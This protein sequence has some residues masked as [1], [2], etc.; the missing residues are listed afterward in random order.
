MLK[1]FRPRTEKEKTLLSNVKGIIGKKTSNLALYQLAVRHS[2]VSKESNERL[3]FLGDAILGSVVAEYLFKKYPYKDEGFLTE[4]R[5][6]IVKRDSLNTIAQ[7]IGLDKIIE[8]NENARGGRT[9]SIYGNALEA[10]VGA[11]YLDKG[12]KFSRKFIISHLV[13]PHI[14]LPQLIEQNLNFKSTLIEWAQKGGK[15]ASFEIIEEKGKK[16]QKQFTSQAVVDGEAIASGT[17]FSKKKAEQSAAEQAC[18]ALGI[19][20]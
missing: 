20:K 18:K 6:R 15:K 8:F 3:E 16:H 11:V 2:S 4:I 1:I 13:K 14:D 12:Y 10:F 17:G 9:A 7:K 5:S 19:I